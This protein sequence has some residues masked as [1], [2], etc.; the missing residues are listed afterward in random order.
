MAVG[1]GPNSE[2]WEKMSPAQRRNYWIRLAVVCAVLGAMA[3]K[4]FFF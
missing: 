3:I 2:R 4:R 1:G